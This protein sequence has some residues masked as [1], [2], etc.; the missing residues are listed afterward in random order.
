MALLPKDQETEEKKLKR[1]IKVYTRAAYFLVAVGI[2]IAY[3]AWQIYSPRSVFSL[4]D[5]GTFLAGTLGP[6]W[7]LA[8]VAIIYVAFLGQQLQLL[9]QQEELKENREELKSAREEV[10]AQK[11]EMQEQNET[12]RLQR[13]ESMFFELLKFHGEIVNSLE[14]P[15]VKILYGPGASDNGRDCFRI[16]YDEL[17]VKFDSIL[18]LA[19]ASEAIRQSY[20]AFYQTRQAIVG[21]YFRHLYKITKFIDDSLLIPEDIELEDEKKSDYADLMR[22]QLSTYEQLLLW[23][24][25]LDTIGKKFKPLVEKYNLVKNVPKAKLL[26]PDHR[27]LYDKI[28]LEEENER[29]TRV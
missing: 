12:L 4:T 25:C 1:K 8:G 6:F 27:I 10:E 19:G 29:L 5:M 9:Y 3:C 17:K 11:K 28:E 2:F 7:A 22:A 24:N 14:I 26:H 21:H 15:D 13:F 16:M 20:T 18:P 23:Y